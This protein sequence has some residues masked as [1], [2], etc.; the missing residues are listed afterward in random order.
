M[1][2]TII[3]NFNERIKPEDVL[4]H[5]G[6]FCFKGENEDGENKSKYWES[7]FNGKIIHTRGNHDKNNSTKTIIEGILIKYGGQQI[8]LVHNPAHFN[9]NYKINFV[10]HVHEKWMFSRIYSHAGFVD[11]INIGVDVWNFR[12]VTIEEIMKKLTWWRKNE[13]RNYSNNV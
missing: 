10:G 8:Y 1:N 3:K 5:N 4:F 13:I 9:N 2:E 6:D 7:K 11:L 12:P